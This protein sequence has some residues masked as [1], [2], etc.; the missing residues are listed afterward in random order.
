MYIIGITPGA[1]TIARGAG[2]EAAREFAGIVEKISYGYT[3]GC[4][5]FQIDQESFGEFIEPEMIRRLAY[6]VEKMNVEWALHGLLFGAELYQTLEH[7]NFTEWKRTH[8]ILNKD[9]ILLYYILTQIK[10]YKYSPKVFPHYTVYH[11]SLEFMVGYTHLGE[12]MALKEVITATPFGKVSWID[13]LEKREELKKW[14]V[15]SG[16]A[17]V[18]ISRELA[19]IRR[20]EKVSSK[21]FVEKVFRVINFFVEDFE[22]DTK[23]NIWNSLEDNKKSE[24]IGS[25]IERILRFPPTPDHLKFEFISNILRSLRDEINKNPLVVLEL[26]DLVKSYEEETKK[27]YLREK[28]GENKK[29][30]YEKYFGEI[31]T[32]S[33]ET[34]DTIFKIWVEISKLGR[35]AGGIFYEDAAMSL[36]AKYVELIAD[37]KIKAEKDDIPYEV[38]KFLRERYLTKNG[39]ILSEK[40]SLEEHVKT[41]YS[42]QKE[43]IDKERLIINLTPQVNVLVSIV[44]WVGHFLVGIEDFPEILDHI[45]SLPESDEKILEDIINFAKLKP[46][47]KLKII[48]EELKKLGIERDVPF[49]IAVETPEGSTPHEGLR[50]ICHLI[51]VFITSEVLN[52]LYRKYSSQQY[53]FFACIDTEHLLSNAFDPEKEIKNLI[54][55]IKTA[56]EVYSRVAIYHIGIPKPYHGTT[57]LPFDVGSEEQFLVY[58]YCYLLKEAGFDEKHNSYLIFERGGGQLPYQFLRTVL[59]ALRLIKKY[60]EMNVSPED[61]IKKEEYAKDFFGISEQELR[62]REI[63]FQHALEPL[64]GL[65]VWPE[66][67]HTL[68]GREAIERY[69]KRPEEWASEELK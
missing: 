6:L 46:I 41:T 10:K 16:L 1:Y 50:R 49:F 26:D 44:Y 63:I 45:K 14:F 55:Y 35:V 27:R 32:S 37:D 69:R 4:N 7:I 66:E 58:R 47:E 48:N 11:A 31:K 3:V 29:D 65:I 21:E 53:A 9:L 24:L 33:K 60:L 15:E 43:L 8:L 40:V 28:F 51:D 57:H 52:I 17:E 62:E 19:R 67:Y 36:V 5:F 34:I 61:L 64:R 42:N 68:F 12:I 54:D 39:K 20:S 25:F 23:K 2:A 56:K 59:L 22:K 18:I 30:V 38:C 13:F